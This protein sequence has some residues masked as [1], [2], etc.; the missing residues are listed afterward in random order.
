MA[1]F[2]AITEQSG[3][4]TQIQDANSLIIGDG[5]K[6]ASGDLEI[7]PAGS[8]VNIPSGKNLDVGGHAAIGSGASISS[9][10]ILSIVESVSVS[11]V[12]PLIGT[13]STIENTSTSAG[14][15]NLIGLFLSAKNSAGGTALPVI[16][17]LDIDATINSSGTFSSGNFIGILSQMIS[18]ASQTGPITDAYNIWVES[19]SYVGTK[20]A[21]NIGLQIDNQGVSGVTTSY[22][23]RIQTQASSTT[24]WALA[25]DGGNSYHV[26]NLKLGASTTPAEVLDVTGNVVVSGIVSL[27]SGS[28][29]A[30]SLTFTGDINCGLFSP[31]AD[32]VGVTSGG[33]TVV[34]IFNLATIA[35]IRSIDR[36]LQLQTTRATDGT[37]PDMLI[38]A[39]PGI[40]AGP[41]AGGNIR[42]S[43]S[44]GVGGGATGNVLFRNSTDSGNVA[45]MTTAGFL[46]LGSAALPTEALDVTGDITYTGQI[47]APDGTAALPSYS[48]S[49]GSGVAGFF[50]DSPVIGVAIAGTHVGRLSAFGSFIIQSIDRGFTLVPQRTTNAGGDDIAILGGGGFG[51]NMAGGD[52]IFRGG[53]PTG[54]GATGFIYV[55]QHTTG[56]VVDIFDHSGQLRLGSA[57]APTAML[58]VTGSLKQASGA[59]TIAANAASSF[60]TSSGALTITAAAGSTW[61]TSS[62]LLNVSAA[63]LLTCT[64]GTGLILSSLASTVAVTPASGNNFVVSVTGGAI[65]D[66]TS[67]SAA[68]FGRAERRKTLTLVNGANNNVA[69]TVGA[70]FHLITGPTLIFNISGIVAGPDGQRLTIYNPTALAMTINNE[71]GSS[72]A[73][74]RI[75]SNTGAD[76]VT[77]AAGSIELIYDTSTSRWLVTAFNA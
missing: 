59:V 2:R 40:G 48:F 51:T 46:K 28:A 1:D 70:T 12:F 29:A 41:S 22:A 8:N 35:Q 71:S 44:D 11:G 50:Y 61:S 77:T 36:E 69:V 64:G 9:A 60:T 31:L 39:G 73:A 33:I 58:D 52:V 68:L 30:P 66:V 47:L 14:F 43:P 72:T 5:I 16:K 75:T 62:G 45:I 15:A 67:A 21:I 63:G 38:K 53:A 10:I 56:T 23:I 6:T 26:G 57:I 25:A 37:G 27:A 4:T 55:Q 24:N 18:T 76:L 34:E 54:T 13:A 49:S 7:T 20:P 3:T 19:P 42:I 74:N 65:M 32:I 17:C